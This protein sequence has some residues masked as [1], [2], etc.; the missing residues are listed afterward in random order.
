VL[1][2]CKVCR[3]KPGGPVYL[4]DWMRL[5][6]NRKPVSLRGDGLDGGGQGASGM[7]ALGG[8]LRLGE[9]VGERPI[10][11]AIKI[12]PFAARYCHYSKEV[13]GWRWP[14]RRADSY[15][16][17]TYKG[18]DPA[19]VMG[20]LLALKPEATPE[21]LGL[22]TVPGRKL[23][24]TL[25]NYGAYFTEDAAWDTWDLIVERDA[26][27][28]F[29]RVHG[30]SMSSRKWLDEVNRLMQALHI[31]DNNGPRSIGGGGTP[32]QPPAPPFGV[33]ERTSSPPNPQVAAAARQAE[34]FVDDME[35]PHDFRPQGIEADW[36][37]HPR[38]GMRKLPDGWTCATMW[39]QIYPARDKSPGE[40][41][42]VQIRD[43][44]LWYLSR[45]DR[46]W[47]PVQGGAS[48]AGAAYVLDFAG[49]RSV[50]ADARQEADD[51]VSVRMMPGYNYHFWP[52]EK[53]RVTLEPEDVAAMA[54]SFMARLVVDDPAKPDDGDRAFL[55]GSCGG[56][57]WR[58]QGVGWK[59][60]WSN[61]GDWAIG[62]FKR[63]GREWQVFTASNADAE[64]L[65][66]NP[67]PVE[68]PAAPTVMAEKT[69]LAKALIAAP[70]PPIVPAIA[71]DRLKPWT[72]RLHERIRENVGKD[73]RPTA[74][75]ALTGGTP[76][77]VRI[78]AA[79][80]QG[81]TVEVNG[82]R[83]PVPWKMLDRRAHSALAQA[84]A[85]EE[86]GEGRLLLGVFLLAG[87]RVQDGERELAR[88]VLLDP[89]LES[90]VEE[91]RA[92]AK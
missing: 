76:E 85:G 66:Q 41:V 24:F 78:V 16:E 18:S 48:V 49:D 12:N 77:K 47:H 39:G 79:D 9:L 26:E 83:L 59:A 92:L 72:D 52:A 57:F 20:T 45:K 19:L 53:V 91:A 23:F 65:R 3:D 43:P 73:A 74:F 87:G 88:A 84:C 11:H 42:R 51:A 34:L 30:F 38:R 32:R 71:D 8:T 55:I 31:V 15:A 44:R 50:N 1:Q 60:D 33:S 58:A 13:P 81:L 61:N 62:R 90:R 36:S 86:D 5:P 28:E 25:Q 68:L 40:N 37:R 6:G 27:K 46:R 21:R 10:R 67:P 64:V 75:L 56:D 4:P 70:Q 2:G 80:E 63:I 35:K 82:G 14:A 17:K 69:P 89:K 29:E 7:S 54:S 22:E